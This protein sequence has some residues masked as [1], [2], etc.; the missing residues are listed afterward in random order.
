MQA[1]KGVYKNGK[2]ELTEPIENI[3]SADLF[4]VVIPHAEQETEA[5]TNHT[6]CGQERIESE[7][8][9]KQIGIAHFFDTKDDADV[10]WEDTFG[11]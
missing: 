9:F 11:L 6:I 2:V 7:E 8:D 3:K 1:V 4:I 10:D 5:E